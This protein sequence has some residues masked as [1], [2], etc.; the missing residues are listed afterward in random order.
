[1]KRSAELSP[2]AEAPSFKRSDKTVNK[3]INTVNKTAQ[4]NSTKFNTP[5]STS[6]PRER[7]YRFERPIVYGGETERM[8]TSTNSVEEVPPEITR[9]NSIV[10]P[11]IDKVIF[12]IYKKDYAIFDGPLPRDAFKVIWTGHIERSMDEVRSVYCERIT[13]KSLKVFYGLK[14]ETNILEITKTHETEFEIK[15]GSKIHIFNARFPQ[16]KEITCELGKLVTLIIYK[17][18]HDI[19]IEDIREW[20]NLFGEIQGNFRYHSR[21]LT[22]YTPKRHS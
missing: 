12:E 1:M 6:T 17:I 7:P 13:G 4:N 16:F 11:P 10:S 9:H 18:P 15:L 14:T 3:T 22:Q 5:A 21:F 8:H 2:S 20:L 19:D